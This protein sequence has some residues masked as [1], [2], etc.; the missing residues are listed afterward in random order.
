MEIPAQVE[1]QGV[2]ASPSLRD[3]IDAQ[4]TGLE[5]RFGGII[6]CRVVLKG[7]GAHHVGGRYEVS[8]RLGLPG[9]REV[10]VGRNMGNDKRRSDLQ[11]AINSAFRRARRG[12]QERVQRLQGQVKT[13]AAEPL[14]V[15]RTFDPGGNFGFLESADG[16]E[17]YFHRNSVLGGAFARLAPG[18]PVTFFE[19]MGEKGLQA[20]TV[21][22]AGKHGGR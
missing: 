15:V 5:K 7:P 10:N 1:F 12:L 3:A 4:I 18:I 21:K 19:E 13:H 9:G 6:S 16:R 2:E 8:I 11:F 14:G 17:I 22:L 20:S